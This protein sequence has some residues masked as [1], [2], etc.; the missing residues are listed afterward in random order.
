M[1]VSTRVG[2]VNVAPRSGGD[3]L[4]STGKLGTIISGVKRFPTP[5]SLTDPAA[6][7]ALFGPVRSV[8][9]GPLEK[10][11]GFSSSTHERVELE[12]EDG[13]R[14]SLVLK[15]TD[16]AKDWIARR[17]GD[18]FG[19]ETLVLSEPRL[20]PVWEIYE[21]PYLAYAI[22]EGR[23]A[24][25]ST[26]LSEWL[27]PDERAPISQSKEQRLIE[28]MARLHATFW[29]ADLHG[30]RG[31]AE[32][33]IVCD[34]VGHA[35]AKDAESLASVHEGVRDSIVRGWARVQDLLPAKDSAWL[36][37]PAESCMEQWSRFPQ[38]LLHGDVKVANFAVLPNGRVAAFDWAVTTLGPCGFELGWY[39]AVNGTRL[40]GSKESFLERYRQALEEALGRHLDET[41]WAPM[42]EVAVFTG[43]RTLLWSK[44]LALDGGT[45]AARREWAWWADRLAALAV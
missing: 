5:A 25:L 20:A 28:A 22:G 36:T 32:P 16:V 38:T 24:L 9:V 2:D 35:L 23:I 40:S 37:R 1:I 4:M 26:D 34:L 10:A 42:V 41:L 12:L 14:R 29:D 33:R 43:A 21:R 45:D 44:A 39:L 11:S 18:T 15:V 27:F 17:T 3:A 7:M 30:V 6:L 13:A 19:R 8:H 31:L